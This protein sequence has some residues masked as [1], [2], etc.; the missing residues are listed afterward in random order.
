MKKL[1]LIMLTALLPMFAA[2][3]KYT[4]HSA[5]GDIRME[6][7][8]QVSMVVEGMEVNATDN[9][10]IGQ[11]AK[12]EILNSVNSKIFTST[13]AGKFNV[14]RIIIDAQIKA[15]DHAANVGSDL[16]MTRLG[17][18]K[19]KNPMW[20]Q[21]GKVT[22]TMEQYD[23]TAEKME[24]DPTHLGNWIAAAAKSGQSKPM[25]VSVTHSTS[26]ESGLTF[27]LENTLDFPV[28][29][30][31]IKIDGDSIATASISELGQPMGSYVVLPGQ[32]ISREQF[33]GLKSSN[34]HILVMTPYYF[35]I[36]QLIPK[37]REA[38]TETGLN[39]SS[40]DTAAY[41]LTL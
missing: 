41:V 32:A 1:F 33:A 10:I 30:N 18:S 9:I 39:V 2:Q 23:P 24:A 22:R 7:N 13:R 34:R 14:T 16:K 40:D 6:R 4:I 3:A 20:V 5:K 31:V 8:G 15:N 17:V 29:F 28:Y 35:D 36:D 26:G 11:D 21:K 38:A 37:I 27:R 12:V 19:G 25:P